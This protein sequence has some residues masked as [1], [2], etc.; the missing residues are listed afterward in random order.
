MSVKR[1]S[2]ALIVGDV[3]GQLPRLERLL[4]EEGI[5]GPCQICAATGDV[6]DGTEDVAFCDLCQGYGLVRVDLDT[7]VIQLGDLM[8]VMPGRTSPTADEMIMGFA[9][10]WIDVFLW[11]NHERPIVGGPT[12]NGYVRPSQEVLDRIER[13]QSEGKIK[14]A[15]HFGD[16]LITHAGLGAAAFTGDWSD[17]SSSH[18][19]HTGSLNR[20]SPKHLSAWINRKDPER[21]YFRKMYDGYGWDLRDNIGYDRGG[22]AYWGGIIWRDAR[23]SLWSIPQIFGH[24]SHKAPMTIEHDSETSYC[25]DTSKHGSLSAVWVWDRE[26]PMVQYQDPR[27][28]TV[29][30]NDE[31]KDWAGEPEPELDPEE[32]R[33]IQEEERKALE[34]LIS[35]MV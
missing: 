6:S 5:L 10:S 8:D 7:E 24:T 2:R 18:R 15:H 4:L 32:E 33:R 31:V 19:E 3:H 25:I 16:F 26:Y 13:W 28:V 1:K 17:D 22:S 9:D 14:L 34:L 30:D 20:Y 29:Y 27:L 11:G 23:E 35:C 21:P 12:F